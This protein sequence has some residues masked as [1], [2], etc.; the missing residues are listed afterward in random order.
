[1][2]DIAWHISQPVTV[3]FMLVQ[4]TDTKSHFL[5]LRHSARDAIQNHLRVRAGARRVE[6]SANFDS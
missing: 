3:V 6:V 1:M 4:Y 2:S 5:F